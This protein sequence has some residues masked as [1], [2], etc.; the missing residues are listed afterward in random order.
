[1]FR[2]GG[3][4]FLTYLEIMLL[5]IVQPVRMLH[6]QIHLFLSSKIPNENGGAINL[7]VFCVGLILLDHCRCCLFLFCTLLS[8]ED[9]TQSLNQRLLTQNGPSWRLRWLMRKKFNKL[10]VYLVLMKYS[11]CTYEVDMYTY[12]VVWYL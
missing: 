1:M 2:F 9:Q 10:V 5:I 12:E 3:N 4:K 11:F 8:Q 7:R 6:S